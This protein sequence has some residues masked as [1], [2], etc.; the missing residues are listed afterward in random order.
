MKTAAMS[1][2]LTI[3]AFLGQ[4]GRIKQAAEA[5][6]EPGS[7]GGE[8]KH[9]VKNVDDRTE[10][11]QEG[12]RSAEN[13]KDVKEDQGAAGVNSQAQAK[14]GAAKRAEGAPMTP[15]SAADDHLQMGTNV[16]ATGDDPANETGKAKAGKTDPGS[17][18]PARTD[19]DGL[20]GHKYAGLSFHK[21]AALA[22]AVGNDLCAQAAWLSQGPAPA[23]AAAKQAAAAKPAAPGVAADLAEAAGYELAGAVGGHDKR[24][25]DQ[26][27]AN[28]LALLVKVAQD[29]AAMVHGWLTEYGEAQTKAAQAKAA[30]G[31]PPPDGGGPPADDGAM[32]AA[33][34][35]GEPADGGMPPPDG[36]AMPPDGGGDDEA[37]AEELAQ[38]LA[39]LNVSPEELQQLLDQQ[40]GDEAP[41][42]AAA[43]GGGMPPPAG[44]AP[45]ME[46]QAR[47]GAAKRPLAKRASAPAT[48]KK[49]GG[50]VPTAE[51]TRQ[52]IVEMIERSRR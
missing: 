13:D 30:N 1:T 43:G 5:H 14:A 36:G 32:L 22:A 39:E 15:G 7:I 31:M 29:R 45:G 3:D 44:G 34:G 33:L 8:T 24:A 23:A 40:G 47:A 38:V 16:Q 50:V 42:D 52:F 49:Q 37:K 18:H 21:L 4:V 20:D 28:E 35:G 27:V 17:K 10:V 11:A 9:P 48:T 46:V 51:Q 19:N 26:V 6:T 25:L 41:P 12:A 2:N